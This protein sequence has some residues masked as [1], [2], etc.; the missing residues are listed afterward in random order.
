MSLKVFEIEVKRI[1]DQHAS[2][3]FGAVKEGD[4]VIPDINTDYVKLLKQLCDA[5]TISMTLRLGSTP[6]KT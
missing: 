1:D 3:T 5:V 4:G 6:S 2:I